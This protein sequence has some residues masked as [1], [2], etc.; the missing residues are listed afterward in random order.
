MAT[1]PKFELIKFPRTDGAPNSIYPVIIYRNVLPTP[2]DQDSVVAMLDGNGYSPYGFFGGIGLQHFHSN[3]HEIYS[4]TA[5]SAAFI[6][7]CAGND[8]IKIG[9][10][11]ELFKGDVLVLP[12]ILTAIAQEIYDIVQ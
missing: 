8:D 3:T 4:F 10:K 7:G 1:S 11:V 12:V 5:G 9:R 2:D 6:L